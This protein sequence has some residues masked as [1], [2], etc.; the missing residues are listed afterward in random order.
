MRTLKIGVIG[1][2]STFTPELASLLAKHEGTLGPIEIRLMDIDADRL[3]IVGALSERLLA[4]ESKQTRIVYAESVEEAVDGVDFVLL[5]L[6]QGGQD[7]RIEDELLGRKYR[8][9]FVETVSICG[10]GAF[11][12]TY[13]EF[14]R[15]A[16]I[17]LVRA[18]NA[19]VMN[20]SNPSGQL[21]EALYR[22][23]IEKVVGVCNGWIGM[24]DHIAQLS[25]IA[26]DQFFMNWK[27]LNHLTF[28]DGIFHNGRNI[29]P[30]ILADVPDEDT[31]F[32]SDLQLAK[33]L[34]AIPNSYLQYYYNRIPMVQKLLK[35]EK[36]RSHLVK[37]I[38][39]EL[40]EI[41]KTADSLPEEIKKRGGYRYSYAVVHILKS[42]YL[43][44]GDVHYGVVKNGTCLPEL[45][46]D[47]FVEVPILVRREALYPVQTGSLPAFARALA[48]T[49]KSYE[50]MAIEAAAQRSR[51][52]LFQAMMVHP[53]MNAYSIAQPLLEDCLKANAPYIP[54]FK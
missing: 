13:Y 12:R 35:Q 3:K 15:I 10:L 26:S 46:A 30:D 25:G 44:A 42:I 27:G 38:D 47:A 11:L 23:G 8:I 50:Q 32:P 39:A 19:W 48:I 24:K 43:D 37:E 51:D 28:I 16:K 5:Q 21:T 49:M 45:P 2:A 14:E 17:I 20:F 6:R 54:E 4:K 40:L 34:G 9:P 29:L 1:G 31:D 41:Y 7:A 33:K 52:L 22:F 18:P 53:I 36:V